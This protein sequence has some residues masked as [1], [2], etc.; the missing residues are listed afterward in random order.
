[1]KKMAIVGIFYDGYKDLWIDFLNLFQKFWPDCPYEL[2]IVNQ[3]EKI[4]TDG[5]FKVLNAGIDAEYSRKVQYAVNNIDAEYFLLL[6]DDFFLSRK[7]EQNTLVNLMEYIIKNEINYCSLPLDDFSSTFKG[8]KITDFKGA[9]KISPKSEYTVSCQPAIWNKN[10]LSQCI[11]N[12]NYNAWVFEG[13]YAKS[14]YAHTSIFLDNCIAQVDNLMHL[15]HGALQGRMIP[16]TSKY[17]KKIGYIMSN[18]RQT[19]SRIQYSK[20]RAKSIVKGIV[21]LKLQKYIKSKIKTKSILEKYSSEINRVMK[22]L[23]ID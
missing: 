23:G 11:G 19:L 2:Y 18:E 9:R 13:V 12:D 14:K 1:M 6:L 5:K 16:K 21:P 10:F 22:N 4:E 8:K 15:K 7:L 3:D 20:H 17:Y